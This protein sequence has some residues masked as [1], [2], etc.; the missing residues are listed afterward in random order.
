MNRLLVLVAAG[1][2]APA[3]FADDKK[4]DPNTYT[5]TSHVGEVNGEVVKVDDKSITLKVPE[6][7]QTGVSRSRRGVVPKLGV[8]HTE[9][10][11]QL[12]DKVVVKTVGGK[13]ADLS[14][15]KVGEAV[16]VHVDKVKEGKL[17]EKLESR[18]EVKRI[19]VPNPTNKK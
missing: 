10:T 3:V 16:R 7:E 13:A 5:A 1:L 12:A 9:V 14:A 18:L 11:Y 19:D 6:V 2:F 15:V 4:A 17:G 8:K